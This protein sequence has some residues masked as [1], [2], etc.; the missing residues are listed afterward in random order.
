MLSKQHIEANLEAVRLLSSFLER[1]VDPVLQETVVLAAQL[2]GAPCALLS[3][4]NETQL[5]RIASF[6]VPCER[7]ER[8][9]TMC[10]QVAASGS[11]LFTADSFADPALCEAG[12]KHGARSYVSVPVCG[13]DRAVLGTLCVFS[14]EAHVFAPEVTERLQGVA[15]LAGQCLSQLYQRAQQ[16]ERNAQAELALETI[17][18]GVYVCNADG[19]IV[20]ANANASAERILGMRL[21]TY[22]TDINSPIWRGFRADGSE[23]STK[24]FPVIRALAGEEVRDFEIGY[25]LH[26]ERRWMD[27]NATPVFD[28]AGKVVQV[29]VTFRDVTKQKNY[30]QELLAALKEAQRAKYFAAAVEEVSEAVAVTDA[31]GRVVDCNDGLVRLFDLAARSDAIG[32]DVAQRRVKRHGLA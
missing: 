11:P 13:G 20:R 9:G 24:E 10:D 22:P 12:K 8:E 7:I 2:S 1:E 4:A 30:E 23:M 28:K 3:L 5:I 26:G 17:A 25:D 15:R 14:T 19:K 29:A 27:S 21:R 6:G 16:S 32:L 31:K 18:E